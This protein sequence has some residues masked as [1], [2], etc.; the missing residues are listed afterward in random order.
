MLLQVSEHVLDLVLHHYVA[1]ILVV[2][3]L[4]PLYC[5]LRNKYFHPLRHFGGPYLGGATDFYHLRLFA[6]KKVHIKLL[7]LHEKYGKRDLT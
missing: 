3:A 1:C 6:S 7:E 4:Y 5:G 2:V